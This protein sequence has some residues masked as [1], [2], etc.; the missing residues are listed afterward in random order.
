MEECAGARS[1]VKKEE[2]EYGAGLPEFNGLS[3]LDDNC[4]LPSDVT[5][6]RHYQPEN[7]SPSHR[8]SHAEPE[9]NK[10]GGAL[11]FA[12]ASPKTPKFNG[13]GLA[14]FELLA[15]AAGWSEATKALQ[16]ALSL[17]EDALAC[18]LLLSPV[19][20]GDYKTLVGALQRRFGQS[21]LRDSLRCEFKHRT[22]QTGE[23]LRSLAYDIESLGRRAYA[24][25]PPVIQSELARDQFVQALTPD[26]LRPSSHLGR[27]PRPGH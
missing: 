11:Q 5:V 23:S 21:S 25:M 19:E 14:Q 7:D 22:R 10:Y 17:T 6:S 12:P 3:W 27:G 8:Q 16:L 1:K 15:S 9:V 26:K 24:D 4:G 20:R 18:L 13:R 2:E